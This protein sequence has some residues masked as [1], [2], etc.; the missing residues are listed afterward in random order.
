MGMP[1][2]NIHIRRVIPRFTLGAFALLYFVSIVSLAHPFAPF[3]PSGQTPQNPTVL[4]ALAGDAATP[5][6]L[7]D[8]DATCNT[9]INTRVVAENVA[10]ITYHASLS[11]TSSN[12]TAAMR[13]ASTNTGSTGQFNPNSSTTTIT[14]PTSGANSCQSTTGVFFD[15]DQC[16]GFGAYVSQLLEKLM[17][18]VYTIVVAMIIWSGVEYITSGTNPEA[19]KRSKNR[20]IGVIIGLIFFVLMRG[21]VS[22]TSSRA[23]KAIPFVPTSNTSTMEHQP[24]QST[25]NI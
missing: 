1:L 10:S 9:Q 16:A 7:Y 8:A 15:Y 14:N 17:P 20:I 23:Q 13:I 5:C 22:L 2:P 25:V 6:L 21:I 19:A 18:I 4:R 12:A 11:T 3:L 24:N